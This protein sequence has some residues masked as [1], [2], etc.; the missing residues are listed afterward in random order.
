[1]QTEGIDLKFK[2]LD[3]LFSNSTIDCNQGLMEGTIPEQGLVIKPYWFSLY[4]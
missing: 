3:I 4:Q 1:M 2:Q